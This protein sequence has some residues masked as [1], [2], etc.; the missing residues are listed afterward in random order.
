[1][2]NFAPSA[3]NGS[4][5]AHQHG[6]G[7]Q[8]QHRSRG[9]ALQ[10]R[11]FARTDHV[12]DHRLREQALDEPAGLEERLMR[13]RVGAEYVHSS[14]K[15]VMSKIELTGPIHTMKRPISLASHLRGLR[16]YSSSMRSNGIDSCEV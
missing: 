11:D 16:R 4:A 2:L 12:H 8:R 10:E 5:I 3:V 1:M 7:G 13:R 14:R 9:D 15:V 6:R